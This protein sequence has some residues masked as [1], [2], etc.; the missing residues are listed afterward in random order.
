MRKQITLR[1]RL[2][3][4]LAFTLIELLVVIAIIAILAAMLLP[5]LSK[6]KQKA[7]ATYCLNSLRQNGLGVM[8]Y[9]NDFNGALVA[10]VSKNLTPGPNY[11][12]NTEWFRLLSPYLSGNNPQKLSTN[13]SVLWGC[14]T[15]MSQANNGAVSASSPG[16]GMNVQPL[17]PDNY[18]PNGTVW[19]PKF[20]NFKLDNIT[21]RTSRVLIGDADDW[22]LSIPSST[23][24]G[25]IRHNG[26]ANYVF[27]DFHVQPLKPDKAAAGITNPAAA[28]F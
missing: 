2:R 25:S 17:L 28:S 1:T 4:C 7:Q 5:A 3:L 27:F 6:A 20:S 23:N 21:Y 13:N 22:P 15:F 16:F 26:Q 9:A 19:D 14:P 18:S 10:T 8:L 12:G 24:K 11:G